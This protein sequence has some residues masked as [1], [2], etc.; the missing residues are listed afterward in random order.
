MT[1][2]LEAGQRGGMLRG[3]AVVLH[4]F[5]D[6]LPP[7]PRTAVFVLGPDI[8][9]GADLQGGARLLWAEVDGQ[10]LDPPGVKLTNA[11]GK[12]VVLD[13]RPELDLVVRVRRRKPRHEQRLDAHLSSAEGALLRALSWP[14]AHTLQAGVA[15]VLFEGERHVARGLMLESATASSPTPDAPTLDDA[16][17]LGGS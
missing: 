14:A 9:I 10:I 11:P 16:P 3:R 4:R 12:P 7:E 5:G 15:E 17:L 6:R 2:W 1:G 8:S 13:F